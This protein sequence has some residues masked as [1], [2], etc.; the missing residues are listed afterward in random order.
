[1]DVNSLN[2]GD[3]VV[4]RKAYCN[5][6]KIY[7]YREPIVIEVDWTKWKQQRRLPNALKE[8]QNR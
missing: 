5:T 2:E 7:S 6:H 8:I 4:H 3:D 1:M